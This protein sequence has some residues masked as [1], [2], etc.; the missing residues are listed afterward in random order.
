M[1]NG[2]L[3]LLSYTTQDHKLRDGTTQS[4]LGPLPSMINQDASL[5]GPGTNLM[6]ETT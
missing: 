5:T 2:L 6:E 3:S 4:G 1:L